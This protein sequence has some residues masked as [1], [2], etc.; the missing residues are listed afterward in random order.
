[1]AANHCN[2]CPGRSIP[3]PLLSL[4]LP[5]RVFILRAPRRALLRMSGVSCPVNPK[6]THAKCID[7]T[8]DRC[9]ARRFGGCCMDGR[10][11]RIRGPLGCRDRAGQRLVAELAAAAGAAT[12]TCQCAAPSGPVLFFRCR[13]FAGGQRA[14]GA[15]IGCLE[16]Q[17]PGGIAGVHCRP[18]GLNYCWIIKQEVLSNVGRSPHILGI[19]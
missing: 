5:G 1:M 2:T 10:A 4:T 3:R 6:Q 9:V 15:G 18:I 13:A 14:A 8:G 7:Y 19:H 12:C 16:A 17:R 11:R